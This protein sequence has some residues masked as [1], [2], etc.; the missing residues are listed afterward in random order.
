MILGRLH[1]HLLAILDADAPPP[2]GPSLV[3]TMG[4]F[5]NAG[6]SVADVQMTL[7]VGSAEGDL[8]AWHQS[9]NAA[10]APVPPTGG[11]LHGWIERLSTGPAQN[12]SPGFISKVLDATDISNGYV[13]IPSL[14]SNCCAVGGVM[15][16]VTS[17]EIT[18]DPASDVTAATSG[19]NRAANVNTLAA[20]DSTPS[21]DG[22]AWTICAWGHGDRDPITYPSGWTPQAESLS[23]DTDAPNHVAAFASKN[24]TSGVPTGT[25]AWTID[26]LAD[27][28]LITYG[29]TFY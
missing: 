26:G 1:E 5:N 22:L 20:V 25:D 29:V 18:L 13:V 15:R 21:A 4:T 11:T 3:G 10:V 2:S 19:F 16:D 6:S 28:T 17:L 23:P 27:A 12:N 8:A 14:G 24:A 9:R 7:P